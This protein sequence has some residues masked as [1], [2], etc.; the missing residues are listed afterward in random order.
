MR[1]RAQ[2]LLPSERTS[3][4]CQRIVITPC[5]VPNVPAECAPVCM[6]AL[7]ASCC[8]I[9]PHSSISRQPYC[10]LCSPAGPTPWH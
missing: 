10:T 9:T 4:S 8:I 5:F 6:S 7:H 3:Y 2:R 1:M